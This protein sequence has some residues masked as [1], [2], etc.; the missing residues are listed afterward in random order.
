MR[1]IQNDPA[2]GQLSEPAEFLPALKSRMSDFM[3]EFSNMSLQQPSNASAVSS[4]NSPL[5]QTTREV[6]AISLKPEVEEAIIKLAAITEYAD[7]RS[8]R[9]RYIVSDAIEKLAAAV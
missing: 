6:E 4:N 1:D 5:S 7:N 3:A 2:H 8:S 9:D